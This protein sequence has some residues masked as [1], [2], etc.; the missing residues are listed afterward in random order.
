MSQVVVENAFEDFGN[1]GQHG[2]M[3]V[4]GDSGFLSGGTG[5]PPFGFSLPPL[6]EFDFTCKSIQAFIK[7]LMTQEMVN[8]VCAITVPDSTKLR[9]IKIKIFRGEHAPRPQIP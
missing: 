7:A 4:Y 8:Y 2:N 1:K 9:V 3:S 5:L 6:G